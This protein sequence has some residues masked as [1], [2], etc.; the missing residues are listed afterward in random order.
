MQIILLERV[1][2]LGQMGD[3][4]KVKPGF[5]RNYL[6]PQ[7]KALRATPDNIKRFETERA[8]LEAQNLERR[9]E[10]EA[11]AAKMADLSVVIIRAASEAGHLYGSVNA[12]DIA[13]VVTAAGFTVTRGQIVL[14]K[15]IKTLGIFDIR[16]RLHPEVTE[17]VKVNVAQSE[18]EAQAQADRVARGEPAVLTAALLDQQEAAQIAAEHAEAMAEAAAANEAAE[19]AE[20]EGEATEGDEGETA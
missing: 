6:L 8:Q 20:A 10:A 19:A 9:N 5:A 12:R 18:E 3:Q 11:V 16:V 17:V 1:E 13:E 2:K 7:G 4:V 15:P 14:D